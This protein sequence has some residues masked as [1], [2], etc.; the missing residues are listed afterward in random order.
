MRWILTWDSRKKMDGRGF[1]YPDP[2][3]GGVSKELVVPPRRR[4][5]PF[6]SPPSSLPS[7]PEKAGS[8]RLHPVMQLL[9]DPPGVGQS[10]WSAPHDRRVLRS[11]RRRLRMKTRRIRRRDWRVFALHGGESFLINTSVTI[12]RSTRLEVSRVSLI[13]LKVLKPFLRTRSLP[14]RL[15]RCPY[16]STRRWSSSSSSIR[17]PR[18]A[19]SRSRRLLLLLPRSQGS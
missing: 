12:I 19:R 17:A 15:A 13:S 14:P 10:P 6:P 11:H 8:N 7:L 9:L 16:S 5:Q 4:E 18:S 1:R 3:P 2:L